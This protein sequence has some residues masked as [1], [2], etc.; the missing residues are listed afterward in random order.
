[1]LL[2]AGPHEDAHLKGGQR[3]AEI[4]F[5]RCQSVTNYVVRRT[6]SSDPKPACSA[7]VHVDSSDTDA[8]IAMPVM[9]C[10]N[11]HRPGVSP[12]HVYS[13]CVARPVTKKEA[14]TN[15][16]ENISCWNEDLVEEWSNV[17]SRAKRSG[18][19]VHIGRIFDILVEKNSELAES[20][21]ARKFKGRVVFEGCCVKDEDSNWAIFSE[22]ASCPASMEAT[23]SADAYGLILGNSIE[24]ADGESAY[25]QAKL[26][27]D[28]KYVRIPKERWPDTRGRKYIDSVCPLVLALCGHPDAGGFWELRCEK[29]FM[30]V[31]LERAAPEWKSVF[32][33]KELDLLLVIYVDDFK[34]VG[35][36]SNW[37]K[38]WKLISSHFK[39][40]P[41]Q[42]V[43]R[44]L[45]CQQE[46]Q[47]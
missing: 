13:A 30:A 10:V 44:F 41:A 39:M 38:G 9:N 3:I 17:A 21:P 31:G 24:I 37:A 2:L 20:D 40:E 29:S 4:K 22:I 32:R 47:K 36:Q 26:G 19:K 28:L 8:I 16:K 35:P 25:T 27:G 34:L 15:P 11:T 7:V 18:T 12:N 23:R 46:L 14:Q 45:G 6:S 43:G 5:T 1:M 33:C 42:P